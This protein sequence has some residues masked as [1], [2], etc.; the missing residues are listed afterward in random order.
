MI[1]H[2]LRKCRL[3]LKSITQF[4][5]TFSFSYTPKSLQNKK[6][7]R[8]I[9]MTKEIPVPKRELID[10]YWNQNKKPREIAKQ[11]GIKNERT[12]RRK[13]ERYGIKRKTLSEAMTIKF[14][15]PFSGDLAEKAYFLGLRA[16]DFHAKRVKKC[17]R[18]QTS[19]THQ[20]QVN[21]LK[22]AFENY[23]DR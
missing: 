4:R 23:G 15:K 6:L 1:F 21:L 11:F 19:T 9:N 14:K 7:W 2:L 8:L 10:L 12:I 20:A 3:R 17:I 16:G 13:M 22:D 5:L 18:I